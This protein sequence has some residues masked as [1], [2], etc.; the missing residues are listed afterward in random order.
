MSIGPFYHELAKVSFVPV[1]LS[2]LLL[3]LSCKGLSEAFLFEFFADAVRNLQNCRG[4]SDA[5]LTV[6]LGPSVPQFQ[7]IQRTISGLVRMRFKNDP[8]DLG[9][10][11]ICRT[12][13]RA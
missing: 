2:L 5:C 6:A 1:N 10:E 3:S 4:L 13:G 11:A 12:M 9:N 8:F 7:E